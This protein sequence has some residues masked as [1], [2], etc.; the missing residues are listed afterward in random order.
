M[1]RAVERVA[2]QGKLAISGV[3]DLDTGGSG[4]RREAEVDAATLAARGDVGDGG[5]RKRRR[6]NL[7]KYVI[8]DYKRGN[9][10]SAV[11]L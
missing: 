6:G 3:V 4:C 1:L 9:G 7:R 10:I 5:E 11:L 2:L 8:V